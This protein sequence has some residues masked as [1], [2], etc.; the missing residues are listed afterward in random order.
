MSG[1]AQGLWG[2]YRDL[3]QLIDPLYNGIPDCSF[4]IPDLAVGK[5]IG[6]RACTTWI[7]QAMP[8]GRF[9]TLFRGL[10]FSRGFDKDWIFF[11]TTYS[12]R[13][14]MPTCA[15]A[16]KFSR[17]QRQALR[18]WI[19]QPEAEDKTAS[20]RAVFLMRL[21]YN[22][23]RTL[24]A[25]HVKGLA[26][27]CLHSFL[28]IDDTTKQ[29]TVQ[30]EHVSQELDHIRAVM[31]SPASDGTPIVDFISKIWHS[32]EWQAGDGDS[33]P[34]PFPAAAILR[35]AFAGLPIL[36]KPEDA[37]IESMASPV[38]NT[39]ETHSPLLTLDDG[40][41]SDGSD[42]LVEYDLE[43][44]IQDSQGKRAKV[45]FVNIYDEG[46]P[47]PF[48]RPTGRFS[49]WPKYIGGSPR[50][51][52]TTRLSSSAIV[53]SH[54]LIQRQEPYGVTASASEHVPHA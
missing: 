29:V 31:T 16:V 38:R 50:T 9:S 14:W 39:Q 11:F 34:P 37:S 21:H 46:W 22:A 44:I 3:W 48:C 17:E 49:K 28:D 54:S 26:V 19:E 13:R 8:F 23:D 10:L 1:H 27:T 51:S 12:L 7:A 45:H 20:D 40:S 53:V 42:R 25:G 4:V 6:F 5:W 52:F 30:K 32:M 41:C 2:R 24:M 18:T 47:V 15:G 33:G 35:P 36:D 43:F